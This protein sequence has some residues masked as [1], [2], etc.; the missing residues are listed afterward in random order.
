MM[1]LPSF[2]AQD[3]YYG[4]EQ[5]FS[6][7]VPVFAPAHNAFP[8]YTYEDCGSVPNDTDLDFNILSE[9]IL[10][11]DLPLLDGQVEPISDQGTHSSSNAT[12]SLATTATSDQNSF[13]DDD[14][15]GENEMDDADDGK[16]RKRKKSDKSKEQIDRRR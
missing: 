6:A 16:G 7:P 4:F 5:S 10:N 15:D 3:Y 8:M 1:S 12:C 9:Y 13:N 11:D 2:P 14:L